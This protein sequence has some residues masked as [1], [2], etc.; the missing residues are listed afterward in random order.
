MVEW[1]KLTAICK[2]ATACIYYKMINNGTVRKVCE[3]KAIILYYFIINWTVHVHQS[4]KLLEQGLEYIV[5][6]LATD[7][8]VLV[9]LLVFTYVYAHI[10]KSVSTNNT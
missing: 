6:I 4:Y 1:C 9:N 2:Q 5:V 3:I 7:L 8:E 10:A